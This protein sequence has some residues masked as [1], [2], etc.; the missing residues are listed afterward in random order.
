MKI[1]FE[2]DMPIP[3]ISNA[4]SILMDRAN[5]CI[6]DIHYDKAEKTVSMKLQRKVVTGFKKTFWGEERP[7]YGQTLIKSYLKIRKVDDFKIEIDDRLV[8]DCKSCFSMFS[9]LWMDKNRLFIGSVEEAQGETLCEI[10][11]MVKAI[12]IE[13]GDD[14]LKEQ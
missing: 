9:G 13:F 6:E 7:V 11:I 12:S 1:I 5:V 3:H 10:S 14:V 8:T 4:L 2:S